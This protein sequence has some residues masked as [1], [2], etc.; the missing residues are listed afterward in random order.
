MANGRAGLVISSDASNNQTGGW[1]PGEENTISGNVAEGM[2]IDGNNNAT[3]A[4]AIVGNN[5]GTDA[6]GSLPR[7]NGGHGISI[8]NA[9]DATIIGGAGVDAGNTIAHNGAV[10]VRLAPNAGTTAMLGN[11]IVANTGLGIDLSDDGVTANDGGDGDSGPNDL[12]NF[13]VP[14]SA[15]ESAGTVTVDFDLDAPAGDYRIEFFTNPSGTDPTGNGEGETFVHAYPVVAHPG[16]AASYSTAYTGSAGDI[17]AATTTEDLGGG[18]FGA[19]SEFSTTLTAGPLIAI[20]NSTGDASDTTPGDG[21]CDTGGLNSEGNPECTHRAAIEEANA[22]TAVSVINYAIPASDAGHTAGIW[23]MT[24]AT[25][26]PVL[27]LPVTL[28]ATTQPGFAGDPVIQ[29]D[30]SAVGSSSA[31]IMIHSDDSEVRGFIVHSF[32]DEGIEIDGLLGGGDRNTVAG[33]WVGIDSTGAAAPNGDN[34]I[35]VA[36]DAVDNTVGGPNP[37]DANVAAGN[38]TGGIG[39]RLPG[40]E[41][42]LIR[43]NFVGVLEDG[44]TPV[45]NGTAGIRLFESAANNTITKNTIR[46]NTGPGVLIELTAL[47]DNAII[48]NEIVG[49]TG[50]GIDID[51]L[52]ANPND[53]GDGDTGPND[54]LNHPVL[55]AASESAG[56]VAIDFDLD[57]PVGDY[58][59]EFFTNASGADPSGFGEGETLV[60]S[61]TVIG[62]PGGSASYS[63]GYTGAAGD[64]ISATTTEH[65]PGPVYGSTSEFS[66]TLT[67]GPLVAVVNSTGDASDTT[68][69]DNV[70]DTGNL[71]S[72]G[73]PECTLRA[74]IEDLNAGSDISDIEF[75]IPVAD[76]GHSAGVWTISPASQLPDITRT[77]TIDAAT[78]SGASANTA[79]AP[80]GL[81][82][83]IAVK[84]DGALAGAGADGFRINAAAPGTEIRGPSHLGRGGRGAARM[85]GAAPRRRLI[86]RRA[87]GPA[88]PGWPAGARRLAVPAACRSRSWRG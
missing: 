79:A 31:G 6:S 38:T 32:V 23:T 46:S 18:N 81:D 48:D 71:N 78:Q 26:Y 73:N 43:G 36:R 42:N 8:F 40:T 39:M 74:A 30:G 12:L 87:C 52:G 44:V 15:N 50:L 77:V 69:G 34:G 24:P 3:T 25:D 11:S 14:T 33:N 22:G 20:V 28:D 88:P 7:G 9:A 54:R 5:I 4:N 10:G 70:C 55:T 47:A 85:V 57:V 84:L 37:D 75:S 45:P 67:A 68:P 64:I 41:N 58:H 35:L 29:L 21:V 65:S 53:G 51:P 76:A 1:G 83:K 16:G 82:T 59:I 62:H 63:T 49:N 2:I 27:T 17:I 19:T 13:P 66:A 56:T 60:H 61:Y 86:R 80:L 72:E